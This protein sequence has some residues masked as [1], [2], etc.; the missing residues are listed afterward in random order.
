MAMS[1]DISA[2]NF[3]ELNELKGRI[4]TRVAEMRETGA[5]ALREKFI[6]EAAALGLS[7]EDIVQAGKKRGRG[8][9]GKHQ[10]AGA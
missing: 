5:P 8:N 6:A 3:G 1:I 2:L 7:M 10:D 4:E 9:A